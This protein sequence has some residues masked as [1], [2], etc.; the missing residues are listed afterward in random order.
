MQ[1]KLDLERLQLV[2]EKVLD[3]YD[4]NQ[5][6]FIE[7]EEINLMMKDTYL[8]MGRD[9]EPLKEDLEGYLFVLDKD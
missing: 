3:E 9:F 8:I 2:A 7:I 4:K 6:G 1:N 5:S